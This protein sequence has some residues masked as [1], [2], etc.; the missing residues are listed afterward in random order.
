M[1]YDIEMIPARPAFDSF[2]F[3]G[4]FYSNIIHHSRNFFLESISSSLLLMILSILV[5]FLDL[6]MRLLQVASNLDSVRVAV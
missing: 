1:A 5:V 4:L 6:L 2:E 3:T